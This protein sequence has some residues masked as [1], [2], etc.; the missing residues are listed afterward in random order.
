M[1][2]SP[3]GSE[4]MRHGFWDTERPET[5]CTPPIGNKPAVSCEGVVSG[6]HEPKRPSLGRQPTDQTHLHARGMTGACPHA[7]GAGMRGTRTPRTGTTWR[8]PAPPV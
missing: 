8:M 5:R 7:L 1:I 6:P 2:A 4:C 3:I